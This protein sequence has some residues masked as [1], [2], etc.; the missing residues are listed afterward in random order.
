MEC[1]SSCMNDAVGLW[2]TLHSH[3]SNLAQ[4]A[5]GCGQCGRLRMSVE[6]AEAEQMAEAEIFWKAEEVVRART[7]T[8]TQKERHVLQVLAC[9]RSPEQTVL[10]HY[11]EI[12]TAAACVEWAEM[13]Q[14]QASITEADMPPGKVTPIRSPVFSLC[15]GVLLADRAKHQ[16]NPPWNCVCLDR[17]YFM[18]GGCEHMARGLRNQTFCD[19][20]R[21]CLRCNR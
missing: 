20:C 19:E 10:R 21:K 12:G 5:K 4:I 18:L 2:T 17:T 7:A 6:Q 15:K 8:L 9:G 11:G 14:G 13:L 3:G 1:S 16:E